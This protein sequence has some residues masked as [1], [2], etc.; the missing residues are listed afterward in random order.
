MVGW[1]CPLVPASASASGRVPIR[2]GAAGKG[3]CNLSHG[4][5][6]GLPGR[7]TAGRDDQA[8]SLWKRARQGVLPLPGSTPHLSHNLPDFCTVPCKAATI[9]SSAWHGDAPGPAEG[10]E[11]TAPR[12]G[13]GKAPGGRILPVAFSG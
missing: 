9:F 13:K 11:Q 12:D 10:T 3:G 8:P 6:P 4:G 1:A 5:G 7:E 2:A